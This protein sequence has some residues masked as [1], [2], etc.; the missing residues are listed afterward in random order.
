MR[1][2]TS[3]AVA[4]AFAVS[5]LL[6]PSS[7]DASERARPLAQPA[8]SSDDGERQLARRRAR[9]KKKRAK[10]KP[11][12]AAPAPAESEP[13]P[14]VQDAVVDA[15]TRRGPT[16]VEFDERLLQGQTN[17][18]NAIYLFQRR[19]SALRSLVKKREHFH[20]EIDEALE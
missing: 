4:L 17:K 9:Q 10:E 11:A 16:R 2:N 8:V 5:S 14:A 19:E 1:H 13:P 3:F 12:E 6:I 15:A 7:G 18:A 20:D